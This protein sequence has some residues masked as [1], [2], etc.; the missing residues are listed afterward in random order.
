MP[1]PINYAALKFQFKMQLLVIL[2]IM[3][4]G[5]VIPVFVFRA[6]KF[7]VNTTRDQLKMHEAVADVTLRYLN[8]SPLDEGSLREARKNMEQLRQDLNATIRLIGIQHARE[9]DFVVYTVSA[10]ILLFSVFMMFYLHRLIG[11]VLRLQKMVALMAMGKDVGEIKVR[12][13]DELQELAK[14][15]ESMRK[16]LL[17]CKEKEG[18]VAQR[19]HVIIQELDSILVKYC[20]LKDESLRPLLDQIGQEIKELKRIEEE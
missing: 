12:S 5:I 8:A 6:S 17:S 20:G 2:P 3:F 14:S 18:T 19:S 13:L 4:I 9:R 15:L 1:K 7:V 10:I 11:P 16:Y